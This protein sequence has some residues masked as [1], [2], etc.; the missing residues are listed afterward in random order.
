MRVD[1][2]FLD[3]K[4]NEGD[5][6][7]DELVKFFFEKGI[8]KQLY[9][10]LQNDLGDGLH[11]RLQSFYSGIRSGADEFDIEK[12]KAGQFF[13]RQYAMEIMMLLGAMSLPYCYAAAPGNK[14]IFLTGKMRSRTGKRLF[15]TAEYIISMMEP[16]CLEKNGKGYFLINKTRLIHALVRF[17]LLR[18]G[19]WN[20]SWGIPI[21]QEDMAGTNLAFSYIIL[22]GLDRQGFRISAE[23]KLNFLYTW[24]FIGFLMHI[25]EDLLAKT[26]EEAEQLEEAIK[27]RNFR[28][29]AEGKQLMKDLTAHYRLS[30]P[31]VASWLVDSQIRFFLG[32]E[33]S[34]MLGMKPHLL[35][36]PLIYLINKGS[37]IYN[38]SK[39]HKPTYEVMIRDHEKSRSRF[40]N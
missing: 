22:K 37:K 27:Q 26:P 39:K 33:I 38:K 29:S 19:T 6:E 16:G 15:D 28:E 4:R 10:S 21:N 13:Y 31:H 11:P 9:Q 23:E 14:A 2:M 18:E 32:K 30:F 1:D 12:I 17:M 36:D 40:G 34:T 35:K 20:N 5:T 24:Q 3:L 8:E 25:D 7:A